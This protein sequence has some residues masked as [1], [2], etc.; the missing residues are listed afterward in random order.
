M[1]L[2]STNKLYYNEIV[3]NFIYKLNIVKEIQAYTN[4]NSIYKYQ[5]KLINI[6][7]IIHDCYTYNYNEKIYIKKSIYNNS[8]SVLLT[9]TNQY[10]DKI[11]F[12][13][14]KKIIPKLDYF[15]MNFTIYGNYKKLKNR[16]CGKNSRNK[17]CL[18]KCSFYDKYCTYH[19]NQQSDIISLPLLEIN[20]SI[21]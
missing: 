18:I 4:L 2:A 21:N 5:N 15:M 13:K 6:F 16:C 7:K 10:P 8:S 12:L 19:K 9:E 3:Y 20:N 14:L 11:K 17:R 1:L